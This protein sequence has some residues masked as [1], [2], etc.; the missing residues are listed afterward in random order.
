M[1]EIWLIG[2]GLVSGAGAG[3]LAGLIG[4]G[5]GIL[6]KVVMTL[7]GIS[8]HRSGGRAAAAGVVVSVPAVLVAIISAAPEGAKDFGSINL[9]MWACIAPAQ[10]AAAWVG[11]QLAQS[12]AE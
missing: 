4:I 2:L 9:S 3:L 6:T 10:A 7:P 12:I 8:S 11:A 5:G 1:S